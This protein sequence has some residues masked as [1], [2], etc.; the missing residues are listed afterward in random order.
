MPKCTR[1]GCSQEF[2][3]G[4]NEEGSCKYHPGGPVSGL[5]T[6]SELDSQLT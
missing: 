3:E 4:K 1:K 2:D 6:A 5:P